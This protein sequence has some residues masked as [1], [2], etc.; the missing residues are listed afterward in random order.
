MA[1]NSRWC[2]KQRSLRRA[3][4]RG[5]GTNAST[6]S[7]SGGDAQPY[8]VELEFENWS[9]GEFAA[10]LSKDK[11]FSVRS[12]PWAT[13]S[14]PDS[15]PSTSGG[16]RVPGEVSSEAAAVLGK[17]GT[18]ASFPVSPSETSGLADEAIKVEVPAQDHS[19][20]G[21]EVLT[22]LS[23]VDK[24]K[25]FEKAQ[26]KQTWWGTFV[27][28]TCS[29]ALFIWGWLRT[30]TFATFHFLVKQ[31]GELFNLS[32]PSPGETV[33]TMGLVT[34]TIAVLLV[35][36]STMDTGFTYVLASL[37]RRSAK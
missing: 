10:M 27:Y 12:D 34:G 22:L 9:K 37:V 11:D 23:E 25:A 8:D 29:I 15:G 19:G 36:I 16:N 6:E 18:R 28:E 24:K 3:G 20:V 35:L 32:W 5:N 4:G 14:E 31:P 7:T 13:D 30:A 21:I 1:H 17:S 2:Q 26:A 33:S